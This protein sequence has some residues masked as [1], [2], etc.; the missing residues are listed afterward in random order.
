MNSEI[1]ITEIPVFCINLDK[2]PDRWQLFRSQ[3]GVKEIPNLKRLAA[4][5]GETVSIKDERI[6]MISRSNILNKVR[7]RHDEID[8]MGAVGASLS[9]STIWKIFLEQYPHKEYCLVFEDDCIVPEHLG[10]AIKEASSRHLHE[11]GQFDMWLLLYQLMDRKVVSLT[12]HWSTPSNFFGFGGY[13]I[14]REGATKLLKNVYPI[15]MHIDRYANMKK[16]FGD[17]EVVV[18]KQIRLFSRSTGSN[19][20]TNRCELCNIPDKIST[21]QYTFLKKTD[22]VFAYI[23]IALS[24]T[25]LLLKNK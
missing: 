25:Y 11:I 22:I 8:T 16:E 18:H 5:D 3:P 15:E 12:D 2:R 21:S 4:V 14:S 1:D 6:G 10:I 17:L 13:I 23:A 9:H 24:V 20:Q 19:I 7:R